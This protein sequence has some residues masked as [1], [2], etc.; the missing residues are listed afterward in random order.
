MPPDL[1]HAC[2][3]IWLLNASFS[4][5]NASLL[6]AQCSMLHDP[7]SMLQACSMLYAPCSMLHAQRSKLNAQAEGSVLNAQCS[8]LSA[9]C[10]VLNAQCS[11]LNTKCCSTLR[12]LSVDSFVLLASLVMHLMTRTCT[13]LLNGSASEPHHWNVC[14]PQQQPQ[15][16]QLVWLY[17]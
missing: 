6:H 1:L 17:Q 4:N 15:L 13:L 8:V 12:L 16:S 9:Q 7:C 10:S 2:L 11:T 3:L 14:C 5:S